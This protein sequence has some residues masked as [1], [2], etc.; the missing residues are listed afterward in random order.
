MSKTAIPFR[1]FNS[2]H[3]VIRL[4]VMMVGK[5]RLSAQWMGLPAIWKTAPDGTKI[6]ALATTDTG[7]DMVVSLDVAQRWSSA[8]FGRVGFADAT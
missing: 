3:E 8:V 6:L 1:Y 7:P 5:Y 4:V 2:S